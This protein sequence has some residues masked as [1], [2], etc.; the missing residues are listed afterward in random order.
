MTY[1][2]GWVAFWST[3]ISESGTGR[4]INWSRVMVSLARTMQV[5]HVGSLTVF[6]NLGATPIAL[7]TTSLSAYVD[8]SLPDYLSTLSGIREAPINGATSTRLANEGGGQVCVRIV[9]SI[10][11]MKSAK[12]Q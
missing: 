9:D 12:H 2:V 4:P 5:T 10:S 7:P 6:T 3:L 1:F 11:N 8:P